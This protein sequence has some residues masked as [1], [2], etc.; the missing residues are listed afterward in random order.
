MVAAWPM[1]AAAVLNQAAG[2]DGSAT[3]LPTA[4]EVVAGYVAHRDRITTLRVQSTRTRVRTLAWSAAMIKQ[5]EAIEA[6]IAEDDQATEAAERPYNAP[7]LAQQAAG[8][9]SQAAQGGDM[10]LPSTDYWT[11]R[12]GI[13]FRF[14]IP[15]GAAPSAF[16]DDPPTTAALG[17]TYR[18]T[19]IVSSPGPGAP[20]ATW[21]GSQ[22]GMAPTGGIFKSYR[23][24]DAKL[25]ATPPFGVV[26]PDWG[27]PLNPYDEF[28]EGPGEFPRVV[29]RAVIDGRPTL[30]LERRTAAMPPR[31]FLTESEFQR[32][33]T[34][35]RRSTLIRAWVDPARGYLPLRLEWDAE[36]LL[37]GKL[38]A[39]PAGTKPNRV[40]E[41]VVLR[42]V[43]PGIFYPSS[44]AIREYQ[45]DPSYKGPTPTVAA[46]VEQGTEGT[47]GPPVVLVETVAW[48]APVV[49]VGR[50]MAGIFALEFPVGTTYYDEVRQ[51]NT[52]RGR[53]FF[54]GP[55][56]PLALAGGVA[57]L[58]VAAGLAYLAWRRFRRP[59]RP[60]KAPAWVEAGGRGR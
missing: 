5:A 18:N 1:I 4:E 37:D 25:I 43:A 3:G 22:N 17:T 40:I 28:Y 8:L 26:R 30:I 20:V 6:R 50:P 2:A 59:R 10:T 11:D 54:D 45:P 32:L 19:I 36:A 31:S 16:P 55:G 38:I 56:L 49:E 23:V 44:G 48:A 60:R 14:R 12:Y 21:N 13:Q 42:E 24:G 29:G 39:P 57:G 53:E 9:R 58:W 27:L 47:A 15:I 35:L 46:W 34:R 52:I 7:Q 41:E 33:G 51:R